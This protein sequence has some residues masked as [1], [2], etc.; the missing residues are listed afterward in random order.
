LPFELGINAP[1]TGV[2]PDGSLGHIALDEDC[3]V[4]LS[5]DDAGQIS[6]LGGRGEHGGST[7]FVTLVTIPL[8]LDSI[9]KEIEFVCSSRRDSL[10]QVVWQDDGT[11]KIQEDVVL[12]GGNTTFGFHA[13]SK[14][15]RSGAGGTQT[16][17]L[18][19]K[20]FEDISCLRGSL[21]VQQIN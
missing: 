2:K 13:S 3:R 7:S 19:A 17:I 6:F 5:D 8:A 15:F 1:K 11:D 12:S 18:R 16:L 10:F 9:Y 20:N 14:R 4:V 21:D